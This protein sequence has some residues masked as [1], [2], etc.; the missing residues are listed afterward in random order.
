MAYHCEKCFYTTELKHNFNLHLLSKKHNEKLDENIKVFSCKKC[1]KI[2][3]SYQGLCK[4]NKKCI[5]EEKDSKN[6]TDK[7]GLIETIETMKQQQNELIEENKKTDYLIEQIETIKQENIK[8]KQYQNEIEQYQNEIEQ[9]NI[10]LNGILETIKLSIMPENSEKIKINNIQYVYLLKEREF[11]ISG[12]PIYKIGKSKQEN[13][14]RIRQYP[15]GSILLFQKICDNCDDSE[16]EL[17]KL[18]NKKYI[19]HT[20]IGSEYFEG[21]VNQMIMDIFEQIK[22]ITAI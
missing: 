5:V 1:N 11:V 18:F 3:K 17:K 13:V 8:I 6:E 20:E 10:Q 22:T 12:K 19:K 21:D 14:C 16:K 4:H 7:T 9:K 15:K 2:Y